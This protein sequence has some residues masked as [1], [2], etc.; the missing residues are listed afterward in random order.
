MST[1]VSVQD[2]RQ[3]RYSVHRSVHGGYFVA[4]GYKRA[5]CPGDR[6]LDECS[7]TEPASAR[8]TLA[9]YRGLVAV[10]R[11]EVIA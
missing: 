3:T 8:E 1:P 2:S 9:R 10:E 7:V 4:K 11:A 6:P 5:G